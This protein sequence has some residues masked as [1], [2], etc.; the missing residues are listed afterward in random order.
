MEESKFQQNSFKLLTTTRDDIISWLA[1]VSH[2]LYNPRQ[3]CVALLDL[4][5]ACGCMPTTHYIASNQLDSRTS[6]HDWQNYQV[7]RYI[8]YNYI[9]SYLVSLRIATST[10]VYILDPDMIYKGICLL[11]LINCVLHYH[12][13]GQLKH[14]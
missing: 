12:Y 1:T 8:S 14:F 11:R 9:N 5:L 13:H 6:K 4:L 3:L 2:N 10:Q 7:W